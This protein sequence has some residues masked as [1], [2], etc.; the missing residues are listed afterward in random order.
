MKQP[1]LRWRRSVTAGLL[2]SSLVVWGGLGAAAATV[3]TYVAGNPKCQDL[4]FANGFKIEMKTGFTSF[5]G[6]YSFDYGGVT[7]RVRITNSTTKT[8]DWQANVGMDAVIVKGG[9]GANVFSYNP[10][11]W[12]GIGL[13]SPNNSGGNQAQISHVDFCFDVDLVCKLG[14]TRIKI[15][16]VT[17]PAG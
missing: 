13:Y 11:A 1:I 5:D 10:E 2:V 15:D 14:H 3:P 16:P 12:S 17:R 4:G 6:T 7:R 9:P 8:F